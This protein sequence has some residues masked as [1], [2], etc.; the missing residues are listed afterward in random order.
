MQLGHCRFDI[1]KQELV[2]TLTGDV[3]HLPRAEF[4]VLC[5]LIDYQG[6][7]VAKPLLKK[8]DGEQAPLSDSSVTRAVFTLR[9]FLGPQYESLIETVKGQGYLLRH[10]RCRKDKDLGSSRNR[11][12]VKLLAGV[13]LTV[14]VIFSCGW[15]A[16][17]STR[18][19]AP[20][21]TPLQT[22]KVKTISG[23]T[24]KVILY[25][26]S[27]T[28]NGLLTEIG[29]TML[30]SFSQCKL[31][32][33]KN[34]YLSLSHDKQVLNVTLRGEQFGQSIIRNLKISDL[35]QPKQFIN[36]QWLQGVDICD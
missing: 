7:V 25:S 19:S 34:V 20:L 4:Q 17:D 10:H 11:A 31:T 36:Q 6:K 12:T 14:L 23:N 29:Q 8:G 9:S 18:L 27:K 22:N 16:Y 3:W 32:S 28:N 5:L 1:D 30:Q 33:W 26:H 13:I 21:P 35:R 2:N 15:I 24:V